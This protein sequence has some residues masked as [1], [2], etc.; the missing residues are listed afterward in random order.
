MGVILNCQ[1]K[2]VDFP[3]INESEE[4][5]VAVIINTNDCSEFYLGLIKNIEVKESPLWLKEWLTVNNIRAI[6]NV[7]DS[8]NLLMLESGQ[9]LH[10][11]DYDALPEQKI[12]VR[13]AHQGERLNAL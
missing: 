3:A 7:V 9:P 11:F 5:L 6:N 13:Q 1:V 8:A 12:V 10:I 4:K 2:P